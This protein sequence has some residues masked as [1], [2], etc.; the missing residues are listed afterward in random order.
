MERLPDNTPLDDPFFAVVRR[1]HPEVDLVILPPVRAA[2]AAAEDH[3]QAPEAEIAASLIEVAT[4]ARDLWS[5]VAPSPPDA[6][7]TADAQDAPDP[8]DARLGFGS[9]AHAVRAIARVSVRRDDGYE[10]L[11]RLRHEMESHGW[12]VR[13]PESAIERLSGALDEH[14]VSAS[15]AE[16]S[17]ALLLTLTGPSYA[18][19]AERACALVRASR[20]NR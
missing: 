20:G 14:D 11:V 17:G 5:A 7:E 12:G 3:D 8:V 19:D 15:Y 4:L 16:Q 13:R 1:R 9:G 2:G 6:A 18:V 10:V